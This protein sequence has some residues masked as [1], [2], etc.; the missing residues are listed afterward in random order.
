[1]KDCDSANLFLLD[2]VKIEARPVGMWWIK[3]GVRITGE[4]LSDGDESHTLIRLAINRTDHGCGLASAHE[5]A[6][7]KRHITIEHGFAQRFEVGFVTSGE[8]HEE[9]TFQKNAA[10][11]DQVPLRRHGE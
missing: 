4:Q 9:L 8:C 11:E 2:F 10:A 6:F 5:L 1:M 3:E 7:Q